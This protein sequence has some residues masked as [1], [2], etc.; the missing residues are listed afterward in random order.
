MANGK[1]QMGRG[2]PRLLV[3]LSVYLFPFSIFHLTGCT[4]KQPYPPEPV[5]HAPLVV[6]DAM[7]HRQWPVSVAHY[8]NGA[9]V[10]WP[11]GAIFKHRDDE[12]VWQAAITDMPMFVANSVATPAVYL[13]TP[14]WQPVVYPE[15]EIEA[16]YHAMPP[17]K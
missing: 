13:F 15:G 6:D 2:A 9:T 5:S 14:P 17:L 10:A 4:V 12:P 11:T 7:Q 8:A 3:G 16:S 1:W